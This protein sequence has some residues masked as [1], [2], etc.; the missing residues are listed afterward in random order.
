MHMLSTIN[1]TPLKDGVVEILNTFV[2]DMKTAHL[3]G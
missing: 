1:Q 2:E 3:E